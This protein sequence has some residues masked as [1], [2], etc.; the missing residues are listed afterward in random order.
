M[1]RPAPIPGTPMAAPP[2]RRGVGAA[3]IA[4]L[5]ALVFLLSSGSFH[6]PSCAHQF[7][8]QSPSLMALDQRDGTV[9][10]E[11]ALSTPALRVW[12]SVAEPALE[13]QPRFLPHRPDPLPKLCDGEGLPLSRRGPPR[14]L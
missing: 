6:E 1:R 3:S 12:L 10:S 4:S 7:R 5:L 8:S 2:W 14:A 9:T 13:P 11:P